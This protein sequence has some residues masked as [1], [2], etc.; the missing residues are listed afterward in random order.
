MKKNVIFVLLVSLFSIGGAFAQI[1]NPY[2]M[3][4][5]TWGYEGC[6]TTMSTNH[7]VLPAGAEVYLDVDLSRCEPEDLG[8]FLF[9]GYYTMKNSSRQ[10]KPKHE[11]FLSIEGEG[12]SLDGS[13][14]IT[15]DEGD[16]M[17]LIARNTHNKTAKLRLRSESGL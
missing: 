12:S 2:G 4:V 3:V 15:L 8:G 9:F 17:R 6:E 5:Y 10:L 16:V 14:F 7:F 11:I 1:D 13:I